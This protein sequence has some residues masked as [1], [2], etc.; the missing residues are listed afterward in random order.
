MKTDNDILGRIGRRDGMTVPDGFFDDF[1]SRMEAS[2]PYRAEAE[3]TMRVIS[4]RSVW[5]RVRPY[6][7]M[8]A[9]FAGIWCMLK[10]F[11]MMAPGNVDL[12]IENNPMLTEALSD[13]NFVY[14]YIVNDINEREILDEMFDDSISVDEM[15]PADELNDFEPFAAES[16]AD[17]VDDM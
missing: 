10:M 16:P 2:L 7:Y 11:T 8:A 3:E 12:S 9:M 4:R 13:D 17:N 6:V 15:I 14:D 5:N 1:A